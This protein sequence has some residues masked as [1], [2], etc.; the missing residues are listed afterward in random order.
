MKDW[1]TMSGTAPPPPGREH[2]AADGAPMLKM[3]AWNLLL[4][5]PLLMLVTPVFNSDSPRLFGLPFFYWYQFLWVPIVVVCVG[6]V[7][8]KT[9]DL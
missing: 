2:R 9:R 1:P 6:T 3:N 7:Y 4:L 5:I 8:L